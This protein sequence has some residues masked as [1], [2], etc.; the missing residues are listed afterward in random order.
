[1]QIY[2]GAVAVLFLFRVYDVDA[3]FWLVMLSYIVTVLFGGIF[4]FVLLGV[5]FGQALYC[6]F[7]LPVSIL[8]SLWVGIF[9]VLF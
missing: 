8:V 4:L 9:F 6:F 3:V 1:M 2:A 7:V 5:N